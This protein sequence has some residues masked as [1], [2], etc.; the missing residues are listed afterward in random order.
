MVAVACHQLQ[1]T[2]QIYAEVYVKAGLGVALASLRQG[3]Q[4][5]SDFPS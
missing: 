3:Y 2:K 5:P 1:R 4:V